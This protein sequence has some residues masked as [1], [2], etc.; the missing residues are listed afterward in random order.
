MNIKFSVSAAVILSLFIFLEGSMFHALGENKMR[1][2]K[3]S[4]D[5]RPPAVAGSFYPGSASQLRKVIVKMLDQVP[6]VT[7][8]GNILAAIAP[9]AGYIFSG[10]VAAHTFK[11]LSHVDFDTFIIIGHDSYRNGV[12]FTCPE[13]YFLT[14]LGRV[15]VDREI[16]DKMHEFNRGIK[17]DRSIHAR[18]HTVEVQLPFL[19]V[20]DK[21]CKVVPILF[22]NPTEENCRILSD[23]INAAA[24]DKKVFVLASTDMSHYPPYEPAKFLDNATLKTL[25]TLDVNELFMHL[26][27]RR[28][29]RSIPNLQTAMCAR[30]GVGTA[31]FFAKSHG[32]DHAQV[33]SYA[34]SGDAAVGEKSRVVGYSSVLIVKKF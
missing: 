32:G 6:D 23:A 27:K 5:I 25:K 18:E 12:A 10:G 31:M 4:H 22:G 16:I 28:G 19:Q 17:E 33:L 20:L 11:Q 15:P 7:P 21:Q 13:D 24:G 26:S 34:N 9:H 14:P 30:G 2:E 29:Q 1:L 8:E 3:V